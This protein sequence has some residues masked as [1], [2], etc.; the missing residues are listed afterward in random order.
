MDILFLTDQGT[1]CTRRPVDGFQG[2]LVHLLGGLMV[3]PL[4]ACRKKHGP[5]WLARGGGAWWLS[6]CELTSEEL[7]PLWFARLNGTVAG[8]VYN[9]SKMHSPFALYAH[10][11]RRW[12]TMRWL[13]GLFYPQHGWIW[14]S[15]VNPGYNCQYPG[16][17]RSVLAWTDSWAWCEAR[18]RI[19][20]TVYIDPTAVQ[21]TRRDQV[22][23]RCCQV[24]R[25]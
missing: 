14:T 10:L 21:V 23:S 25:R 1:S 18:D 15:A 19:H 13:C 3:K 22:L 8:A 4:W 2:F 12:Q 16:P 24:G 9:L 7:W 20:F 17:A 5:F 6:R 11:P